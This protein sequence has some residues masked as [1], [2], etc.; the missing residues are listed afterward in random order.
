M[1]M[2]T[3]PNTLNKVIHHIAEIPRSRALFWK[4][5]IHHGHS[6]TAAKEPTNITC[7]H[8]PWTQTKYKL[9]C[10]TNR[11]TSGQGN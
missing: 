2:R 10:I 8:A 11:I 5:Y 4:D 7:P 1:K 3:K 9:E 6:C